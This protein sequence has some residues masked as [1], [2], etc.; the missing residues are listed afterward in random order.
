MKSYIIPFSDTPELSPVISVANYPWSENGFKPKMTVR[1]AV[2]SEKLSIY[3]DTDEKAPLSRFT[4]IGDPVYKDSCMEFFFSPNGDKRYVNLEINPKGCFLCGFGETRQGRTS[5]DIL[6]SSPRG[7]ITD[8]GW[9]VYAEISIE[10]IKKLFG[11][12]RIDY[13]LGNFYKCG[14]E[15]PLPHYGMWSDIISESPDFHRPEFF[16]KLLLEEGV[17]L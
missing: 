2:N 17:A 5:A 9:E 4:N 10:K 12:E 13:F 15:T 6:L 16:G 8:F 14:D 7:E 1:L 3:M 11:I